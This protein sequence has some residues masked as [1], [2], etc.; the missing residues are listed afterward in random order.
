MCWAGDLPGK[1]YGSPGR[2]ADFYDW[3]VG[4]KPRQNGNLRFQ[5]PPPQFVTNWGGGWTFDLKN[6]IF[7]F[8]LIFFLEPSKK[9][10]SGCFDI[11]KSN[12]GQNLDPVHRRNFFFFKKEHFFSIF[13]FSK[14]KFWSKKC[15]FFENNL[16]P[17][18]C[19]G[20][21]CYPILLLHISKHSL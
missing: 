14:K 16:F 9:V 15:F 8:F 11:C 5:P 21:K 4:N 17:I 10:Y 1:L 3:P 2:S 6:F 19:T 12:I 13:F 7:D 20:P 18:Q